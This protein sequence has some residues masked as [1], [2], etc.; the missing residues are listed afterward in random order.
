[1]QRYT[2][3]STTRRRIPY[4]VVRGASNWVHSPLIKKA[5]GLWEAGPIIDNF[6]Q[7]YK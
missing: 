1:M 2:S 4:V 6:D 7:G 3:L 5:N